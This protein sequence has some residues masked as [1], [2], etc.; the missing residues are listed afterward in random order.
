M[1]LN[2]IKEAIP[3][4]S[5]YGAVYVEFTVSLPPKDVRL[6]T[7]AVEGWERDPVNAVNPFDTTVARKHPNSL[8]YIS[9]LTLPA[10]INHH[11]GSLDTGRRRSSRA[12]KD[13]CTRS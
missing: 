11:E 8:L 6:W 10:R 13:H 1:L 2:G 3:A 4:R 5:F 9:Y 12:V 7:E